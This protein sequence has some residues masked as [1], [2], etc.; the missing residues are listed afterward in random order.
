MKP[1][2][3]LDSISVETQSE[4]NNKQKS[5]IRLASSAIRAEF[6]HEL[7]VGIVLIGGRDSRRKSQGINRKV[8]KMIIIISRLEYTTYKYYNMLNQTQSL[9][10]PDAHFKLVV[11]C[12]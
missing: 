7:I 11:V 6:S 5:S 10:S 3:P 8:T 12:N 9:S 2:P 1:I 4:M